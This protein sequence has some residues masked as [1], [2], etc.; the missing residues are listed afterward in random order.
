MKLMSNILLGI[1]LIFA[2]AAHAQLP[3]KV[4]VKS[5]THVAH[6]RP[7]S[8]GVLVGNTLYL[9]GQGSARPDG[10]MPKTMEGEVRQCL[11]NIRN[12]LLGAG[13]DM[14]NVVSGYVFLE[15]MDDYTV[16]NEV[17]REYFPVDPPVRSTLEAGKIPG[18]S[19]I[20][21]QTIAVQDGVHKAIIGGREGQLFSPGIKVNNLLYISGK[22]TQIPGEDGA[23]AD[24]YKHR[25]RQAILN[26]GDVL[27]IA[28]LDYRH[29]VFCN[30]YIMPPNQDWKPMNLVYRQFFQ[31]GKTPARATVTMSDIPGASSDFELSGVAVTDLKMRRVIRPRSRELSPTA[32]PAVMAGRVLYSSGLSGFVPGQGKIS[33]DF[34]T[35]LKQAMR[36]VQDVLE[37]AGMTFSNVV[38]VNVYLRDM[39]DYAKL[40]DIYGGFFPDGYPARTTLQANP[41]GDT[42]NALVQFSIIAVKSVTEVPQEQVQRREEIRIVRPGQRP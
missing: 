1:V 10:S 25:V 31:Y 23:S 35:Q 18:D 38:C 7:Y 42:S 36:N 4:I 32:S 5:E 15:N 20:E 19:R 8:D 22:G 29:V 2:G 24:L 34:E 39:D 37:A 9:S 6:G 30:P 33:D 3:E 13:M 28:A 21:I 41:D 16:M 27:N 17:W 12:I 11:D 14:H 40:N 26:M